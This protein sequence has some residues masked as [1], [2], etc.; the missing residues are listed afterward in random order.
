MS[1]EI[2]GKL[3]DPFL[4]ADGTRMSPEEWYEK[5][6]ELRDRICMTEFGGIPPKPEYFRMQRLT[7]ARTDG[8]QNVYKIWA[9]TNDAQVQFLLDIT[10]PVGPIDGSV[11]Y[12]VLLTGDGCYTTC[13]SDTIKK[14]KEMGF[15][16]ARFN[17]LEFASDDKLQ[18]RIGGLYDVYPE[19]KDFTATL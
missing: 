14:A 6:G 18:G 8:G 5:R 2:L 9:G 19:N 16:V 11:K 3:P 13:E 7:A 17:R 4:K 10:A 12:P 15:A 1:V